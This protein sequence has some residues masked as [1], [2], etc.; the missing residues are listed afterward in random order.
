M[1]AVDMAG[2]ISQVMVGKANNVNAG[3]SYSSGCWTYQL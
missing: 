2:H 1:G 3:E